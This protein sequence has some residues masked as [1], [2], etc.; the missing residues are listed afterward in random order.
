MTN[1]EDKP[2]NRKKMLHWL[3]SWRRRVVRWWSHWRRPKPQCVGL[4]LSGGAVRG[5]A[6]IGVLQVLE[7]AGIPIGCIV[8]VSAGSLVGAGYAAGL[9]PSE[10]EQMAMRLRWKH[11][12]RVSRPRLGLLDISPLE[13]YIDEAFGPG[14]TFSDLRIPFAAVA[15]DIVASELVVL[16]EGPIAPAVRASCS[17]PTIFSPARL[18]GRLLVDGGVLNNLPVSVAWDMGADYVI[19]V[20][21]LPR[22]ALSREP[23]HLMEMLT[24]TIYTLM[25]A[26]H[27]EADQASCL[28][29][30]RV[31]HLS[32][33]DFSNATALLEAGRAAARVALPQLLYDLHMADIH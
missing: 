25:Q 20:D 18:N 14:L 8:G 26:T 29:T 10:L 33:T 7:E 9:S 16:R 31:V 1:Q 4:V 3:G 5:I 32:L 23:R 19:A 12:S 6:H 28:I 2:A 17:V 13:D 15:T 11:I 24:A 22:G 30:P 21:L 27:F